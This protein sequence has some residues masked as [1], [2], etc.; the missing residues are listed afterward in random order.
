MEDPD[1]DRRAWLNNHGSRSGGKSIGTSCTTDILRTIT[2]ALQHKHDK[3]GDIIIVVIQERFLVEGSL[4]AFDDLIT[5]T[6]FPEHR[7]DDVKQ[8]EYIVFGAVLAQ[9]VFSRI[10]F[11]SMKA[12]EHLDI[13]PQLRGNKYLKEV[14]RSSI[15][16]PKNFDPN[17]GDTRLFL[18]AILGHQFDAFPNDSATW[19]LLV[20]FTA[21]ANHQVHMQDTSAYERQLD[22]DA[23]KGL[24]KILRDVKTMKKQNSATI[25]CNEERVRRESV[26][27][28]GAIKE[29]AL[30]N[31]LPII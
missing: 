17:S 2:I 20:H 24:E 15:S 22:P 19:Q 8:N 27:V 29:W 26:D 7:F 9:P 11:D 5:W 31:P 1:F 12:W 30:G 14:R 6:K 23:M 13:F 25:L 3:K 28:E 10:T 21:L 4:H 18:V 16:G